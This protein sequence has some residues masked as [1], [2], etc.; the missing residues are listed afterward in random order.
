MKAFVLIEVSGN[1]CSAD[2]FEVLGLYE[3]QEL[4]EA[5]AKTKSKGLAHI[6]FEISEWEVIE[7]K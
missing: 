5:A 3:T 6:G 2:G 1:C 7:D 4:A